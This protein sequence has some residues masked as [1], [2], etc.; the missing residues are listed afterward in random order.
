MKTSKKIGL[1]LLTLGLAATLVACGGGG[2]D[3]ATDESKASGSDGAS[4]DKYSAA[5][6]TDLGGVDDRSFNQ[7]AWEGLQKWGKENGKEKGTGGFTYYQSNSD[8]DFTPNLNTAVNDGFNIIFGIGFKLKDAIAEVAAANTDKHFALIDDVIEGQDNVASVIFYDNEAS[9]L[10][11]VAAAMATESNKIGFVGGQEGEVIGRFEAGFIAGAKSVNKDIEVDVKYA[12][13]FGDAAKGKSIA[14]AMYKS[15]IDVIFHASGDT[16]NGV[17][18][19]AKD[20]MKA[21]DSKKVWVI[22]VDRD[23]HDEGD[24]GKGNVTLTSTLK[25]VG[26]VVEDI[27]KQDQDGKFPGGETLVYGLKDGGVDLTEGQL[28]DVNKDIQPAIDKAKEDIK[29]GTIEVPQKP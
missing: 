22:G 6:V 28:N 27:I 13:S 15:G 19:E 20:I 9:Y 2:K 4:S 8:Q 26:T 25:A 29:A 11:G 24:Y 10:A 1:G 23:Q 18:A 17:F 16:G 21:D 14:A 5:L 3:K 7:S 12:G